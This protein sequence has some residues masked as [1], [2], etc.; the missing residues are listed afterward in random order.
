MR[1]KWFNPPSTYS[2]SALISC[3]TTLPR[4]PPQ[5]LVIHLEILFKAI[6]YGALLFI[7]TV[8]HRIKLKLHLEQTFAWGPH[9]N[10]L[11]VNNTNNTKGSYKGPKAAVQL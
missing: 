1:G 7:K 6:T 9:F 8:Q 11:T 3:M 5:K 10:N 4:N 2:L